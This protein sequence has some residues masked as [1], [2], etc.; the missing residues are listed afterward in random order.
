MFHKWEYKDDITCRMCGKLA[1]KGV[2]VNFKFP[3]IEYDMCPECVFEIGS[4]EEK[5][6]NFV[7]SLVEEV[8]KE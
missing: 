6:D 4:D 5:M 2:H 7:K 3:K 8:V 1:K